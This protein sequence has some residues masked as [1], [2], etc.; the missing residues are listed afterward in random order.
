MRFH[1]Q[2]P[3]GKAWYAHYAAA[4]LE[5]LSDEERRAEYN[6]FSAEWEEKMGRPKPTTAGSL[7]TGH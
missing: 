4:G 5:R 6:R 3:F 2:S 1:P 7:D